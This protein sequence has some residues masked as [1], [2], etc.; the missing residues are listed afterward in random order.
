MRVRRDK[1]PCASRRVWPYWLGGAVLYGFAWPWTGAVNLSFLAWFAFVPLFVELRR[2]DRFVPFA[3]RALGFMTVATTIY[4]FGWFFGVPQAVMPLTGVGGIVQILLEATPL[5]LLFPLK[6]RLPYERALLALAFIWPLWEWLYH[7]LPLS[8]SFLLVGNSQ[9]ANVWLVQ[10][11][12]LFG[13]W[14][15]TAWVVLFNVV[16]YTQYERAGDRFTAAFRWG[17]LRGTAL[18]LALPLGYST[19]RYAMLEGEARGPRLHVTLVSTDV[20]PNANRAEQR[21]SDIERVVHLTDST[22]YYARRPTDLYVWTEGTLGHDWNFSATKAFIY[23]AVDDW[24]TP[25]LTGT[26]TREARAN[27]AGVADTVLLNQ[28]VLIPAT[29]GAA[30]PLHAYS[31]IEL[32]PGWEGIP[33]YRYLK[34]LPTVRAYHAATGKLTPGEAP[35]PLPLRLR[36]GRTVPLGTPICHEANYPELWAAMTREGAEAFVQLSFESWFGR[37]GFQHILTNITR[38]R[39][40]ETRRATARSANGGPTVFI[41]AFGKMGRRTV[42]GEGVNAAYLTARQGQTLYTRFPHL[43]ILLCLGGLLGLVVEHRRRPQQEEAVLAA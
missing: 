10:Y 36:D 31:K 17:A 4:C 29:G 25:L 22:A 6:K 8:L 11:V 3:G 30:R 5:L 14:A 15:V 12:D 28:A 39:S 38:L 1:K 34:A 16:L 27:E 43:F 9:G 2:H 7:K 26:V 21:V 33:L 32:M 40:I 37:V 23:D 41:D 18:L 24:R 19:A 13:V 20:P 35:T 42:E